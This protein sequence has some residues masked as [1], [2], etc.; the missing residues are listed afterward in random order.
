MKFDCFLSSVGFW[1]ISCLILNFFFLV[2]GVCYCRYIRCDSCR[3]LAF[4][5]ESSLQSRQQ[6]SRILGFDKKRNETKVIT[7]RNLRVWFSS[8]IC[9]KFG[10]LFVWHL[11]VPWWQNDKNRCQLQERYSS[12]WNSM[13]VTTYF[14]EYH[15]N[16]N[17]EQQKQYLCISC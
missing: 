5:L 2:C 9:E 7:R 6:N 17:N 11:N 10:F 3:V 15:S 8:T 4:I 14:Q 16:Q 12:N 13:C 1:H